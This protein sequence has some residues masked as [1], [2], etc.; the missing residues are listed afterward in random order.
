[1]RIEAF[2]AQVI[3][4]FREFYCSDYGK[5]TGTII[6]HKWFLN[7]YSKSGPIKSEPLNRTFFKI[8]ENLDFW[9]DWRGL[10]IWLTA[11]NLFYFPFYVLLRIALT[12]L[13]YGS[14]TR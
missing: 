1:M 6:P 11:T 2:V 4:I 7:W 13:S 12:D 3:L 5:K 10:K 14:S 9:S 8:V